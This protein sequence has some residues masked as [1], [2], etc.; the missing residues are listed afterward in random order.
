MNSSLNSILV[1]I[2]DSSQATLLYSGPQQEMGKFS[3]IDSIDNYKIL[4]AR[5]W[6]IGADGTKFNQ[7]TRFLDKQSAYKTSYGMYAIYSEAFGH[8]IGCTFDLYDN[9]VIFYDCAASWGYNPSIEI[10]GVK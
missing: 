9:V 4:Y 1:Q 6:A 10:Y 8:H 5:I 3:L 2:G 7:V